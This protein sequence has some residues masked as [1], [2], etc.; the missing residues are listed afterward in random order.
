MLSVL[1]GM[2]RT[3]RTGWGTLLKEN[4]NVGVDEYIHHYSRFLEFD[5]TAVTHQAKKV[6]MSNGTPSELQ[7][8][9]IL[10]LCCA[11]ADELRDLHF[12]LAALHKFFSHRYKYPVVILHDRLNST[13]MISLSASFPS[14]E[15][16]QFE[17]IKL[18][19]PRNMSKE[20]RT[21]IP[22]HLN[23]AGHQWSLGYRHMSNFFCDDIFE[24]SLFQ[25]YEYYWRLDADS[26]ILTD[27][28]FDVFQQMALE[29]KIYGYMLIS[30]EDA[31]VVDGLWEVT[32]NYIS[33]SGLEPKSLK[34]HL[35][36]G[37]VWNRN[38]FY[39]NFEISRFDFWRSKEFRDFWNEIQ[40]SQ[41]VYYKRWGDAP[42]HLLA[43]ALLLEKK[44]VREF[45][46]V[47]YWHQYYVNLS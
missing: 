29:R 14:P 33:N 21:K 15:L 47:S 27:I 43:V 9:V 24:L 44:D 42:I 36:E 30:Q 12:S 35:T 32:Q 46:E 6:E 3:L 8:A 40:R 45:Q 10:Y 4:S 39:T 37:G 17:K 38:M 31:S 26:F 25:Q 20:D 34:Q 28:R 41:G 13:D 19:F 16:L 22:K 5:P 7:S 2:T 18:D 1:D 11:D 23:L